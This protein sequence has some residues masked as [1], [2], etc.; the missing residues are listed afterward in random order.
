MGFLE[1]NLLWFLVPKMGCA[2]DAGVW[3]FRVWCYVD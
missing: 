1:A 2:A 3:C